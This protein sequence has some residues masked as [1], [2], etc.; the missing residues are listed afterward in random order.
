MKKIYILFFIPAVILLIYALYSS[1]NL[2]LNLQVKFSDPSKPPLVGDWVVNKFVIINN[3]NSVK[4]EAKYLGRIAHFSKDII[5]DDKEICED[6]SYK[7]KRVN[8]KN[9]FWDTYKI[10]TSAIDIKEEYIYVVTASS[11]DRYFADYIKINDNLLLRELN[12]TLLFLSKSD[13]ANKYI[14]DKSKKALDYKQLANDKEKEVKAKSGVL[15]SL[16]HKNS[17]T[18]GPQYLYRTLWISIVNNNYMPITETKD[19]LLPRMNGFWKLGE[20]KGIWAYALKNG[21]NM[22]KERIRN[23]NKNIGGSILFVGHDYVSIEDKQNRL[24]VLP[25]DNLLGESIKLSKTFGQELSNS[26]L[27]GIRYFSDSVNEKDLKETDWGVFRRGGRWILRGRIMNPYKEFDITYATPKS[28]IRYDDLYPSFNIIKTKVP[29]AVDA[30]SSPNRDFV[31]VLTSKELLVLEI[32]DGKLGDI[33]N[34]IS[35]NDEEVAIMAHWATGAYV[36]EWGNKVK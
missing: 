15:I 36:D 9:Y 23:I 24:Q 34:R 11:N 30:Y 35:L 29:E 17:K 5:A 14:E 21:V 16:K 19:I 8:S 25:I 32:T 4:E 22:D 18:N 28:L 13:V 26:L 27:N 20:D 6:P 1:L 31:V 2:S 10:K 3:D 7:I 33:K 12:G